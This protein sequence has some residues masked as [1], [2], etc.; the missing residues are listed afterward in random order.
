MHFSAEGQTGL[1]E[2]GTGLTVFLNQG[3][4]AKLRVITEQHSVN[5][6]FCD[7]LPSTVQTR[8]ELD[9]VGSQMSVNETG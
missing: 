3:P 1:T 5:Q 6:S 4:K 2:F 7:S 8:A 9:D